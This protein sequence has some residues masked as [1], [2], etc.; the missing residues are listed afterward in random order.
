[1]QKYIKPREE[2]EA[3]PYQSTA[4]EKVPQMH[5]ILVMLDNYIKYSTGIFACLVMKKNPARSAV[6]DQT[7]HISLFALSYCFPA[8]SLM[9]LHIETIGDLNNDSRLT[10]HVFWRCRIGFSSSN[11]RVSDH[12]LSASSVL[13]SCTST[14]ASLTTPSC[15]HA[16]SFS[17]PTLSF[18]CTSYWAVVDS[19][20]R[21]ICSC[22]VLK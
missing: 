17:S 9:L 6:Q 16:L 2:L 14:M 8:A 3:H 10:Y 12:R 19:C 18:K 11:T 22:L 4:E 1:M 20:C 13:P 21:V 5:V 7:I 15:A